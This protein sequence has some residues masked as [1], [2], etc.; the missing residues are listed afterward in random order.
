MQHLQPPIPPQVYRLAIAKFS[1]TTTAIDHVGPLTWNH[2]PGSGDLACIFEKFLDFGSVPSR[3][4]QKV[5]RGDGILEQLDLVFFIRMTRMQAQLIPPPRSQFAV[6]VKSPCLAVKYPHGETHIRR[7]QIKFTTERDYFTALTLLGEINCPL[8]E[9]K[10][11]VPAIQRF[12]SVSSWTSGQLSSV[13]PRTTNTAATSTGSNGVHSYPTEALGSGRTTPIRASSPASTISH[14]TSRL[15][16]VP[17]LNPPFHIMEPVDLSQPLHESALAHTLNKEPDLP[18]SQLS[19]MSAIH[20]VDQLNQMLP[21]KRDLPFSKPTA[22]KPCAASLTRTTEKYPQPVPSPSSQHTEPTKDPQP[23]LH[24]L[25]VKPNAYSKLP[26]SDSQLLSQTNPCPEASQPLLLHEEPPAS[27]NTGPICQSAEQTS[28]VPS[29]QNASDTQKNPT[30]SNSN[31]NP[32]SKPS[33]KSP[34]LTEDHIAQYLS[35]PT[36]ER[37]VFLENWMCELIDDDGFMGLCE[38]VDRTWRRF[39][40]GQKQ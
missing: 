10:I 24:P 40:F 18:S 23:D 28:Q 39:A 29:G 2:V 30:N 1:H 7:F 33:N 32:A 15:G 4:I 31:H 11:P 37:I 25:V 12:P 19:T 35:S 38:D 16:P 3:M 13:A 36:A 6:V 9:G 14:P 34:V 21:P 17:A 8:T 22:R 26:D 5:V 27:Q 20:D